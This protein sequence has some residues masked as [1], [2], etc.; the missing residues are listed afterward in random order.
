MAVLKQDLQKGT[1]LVHFWPRG[2]TP[3]VESKK[4]SEKSAGRVQQLHDLRSMCLL[5]PAV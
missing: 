4:A 3:M 2:R 1:V 5:V